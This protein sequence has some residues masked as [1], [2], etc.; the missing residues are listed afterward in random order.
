MRKVRPDAIH[1]F[2]RVEI[3][4]HWLHVVPFFVLFVTGIALYRPY[5]NG[6]AE[7]FGGFSTTRVIHRVAG[8]VFFLSWMVH[9]LLD[10]QGFVQ[11]LRDFVII[12]RHEWKGF[13]T[14][15]ATGARVPP[16]TGKYNVGQKALFYLTCGG[17]AVMSASG[18]ILWFSGLF[19]EALVRW[20]YPVHDG[21]MI[22]MTMVVLG[23]VYLAT[24]AYQGCMSAMTH[25]YVTREWAKRF[26]PAWFE[27]VTSE[28]VDPEPE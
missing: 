22:L 12:R 7:A 26:H 20:M 8:V 24:I 23:H 1:R 16:G 13:M 21:F 3:A 17:G 11:L 6:L 5:L 2:T 9:P 25:G 4:A 18:F 28:E 19:P 14:A 15:F 10:F 27:R